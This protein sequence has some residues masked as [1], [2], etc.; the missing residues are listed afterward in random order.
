MVQLAQALGMKTLAEGIEDPLV[1]SLLRDMGCDRGQGFLFGRPMTADQLPGWI[2]R[3]EPA[4]SSGS[5]L[6]AGPELE[7]QR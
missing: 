7:P 6:A 3:A 2:G 4:P 5:L 1:A